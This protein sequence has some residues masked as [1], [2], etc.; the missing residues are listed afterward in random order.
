MS[1]SRLAL[2]SAVGLVGLLA[3]CDQGRLHK[4]LSQARSRLPSGT[5]HPTRSSHLDTHSAIPGTHGDA[6]M[7]IYAIAVALI[8]AAVAAGALLLWLSDREHS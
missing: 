6:G 1:Q 8:L 2:A 7:I 3:A 5:L 4:G